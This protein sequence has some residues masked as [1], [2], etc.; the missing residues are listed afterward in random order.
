MDLGLKG[1]CALV[2][3]S[4]SGLGRAIA[5]ALASEG[6]RVVVTG[7]SEDRLAACVASIR[8]RGGEAQ[9]V[10]ADLGAAESAEIIHRAAV[11]AFGDI[12][13]LV[14]NSGGP[15]TGAP[16]E[17]TTGDWTR[18]FSTMVLPLFAITRLALE[19]MRERRWGRIIT[20]ASSGVVEP[21]A[22]LPISNAL[23]LSIVGWMKSLANEVAA[24]GVT[25]NIVAPGRIDTDRVRQIN[26]ASAAKQGCLPEDVARSSLSAIPA[27][28]YGS[29]EEFAAVVAF[30]AGAPA[31]YVTGSV[32]RVDGGLLRSV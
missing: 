11:R 28:R 13:V 25:V 12:Q 7:R 23:R 27:G 8:S 1:K 17:I 14:N 30:L 16:S 6:A 3:A 2:L 24:D 9:A 4:S 21:I 29:V 15:P 26:A 20:I 32:L 5:H 18:E 31:S 10:V 22:N 19:S